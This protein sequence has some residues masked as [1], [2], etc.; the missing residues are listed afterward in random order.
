M[1]ILTS[2]TLFKG[3]SLNGQENGSLCVPN[4]HIY[5]F[6]PGSATGWHTSRT[7]FPVCHTVIRPSGNIRHL[8]ETIRIK[9]LNIAYRL[10][11]VHLMYTVYFKFYFSF[12]R[13][14]L[15]VT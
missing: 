2:V 15:S 1:H 12:N 6:H 7:A 3:T 11:H 5:P 14:M 4:A 10:T 9:I 13:Q 8:R